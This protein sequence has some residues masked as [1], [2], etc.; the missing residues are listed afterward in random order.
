MKNIFRN[1]FMASLVVAG[2]AYL[3]SCSKDSEVENII[4]EVEDVT[5]PGTEEEDGYFIA[6][7][8]SG[9]YNPITRAAISGKSSRVQSLRYII[10]KKD[11]NG[12]YQYF[13]DPLKQN[14]KYLFG[15]S[16]KI[17]DG[18]SVM[19][20]YKPLSVKL[21]NGDYKFVFL[22]N[23][24]EKQFVNGEAQNAPIVTNYKG[25]YTDAR[26]NLPTV[27]GFYEKAIT[28][29]SSDKESNFFYWDTVEV[30]TS[31]PNAEVLLQRI[32]SKFEMSREILSTEDGS[33]ARVALTST[34]TKNIFDY[35]EGDGTITR[36][37]GGQIGEITRGVFEDLGID[38]LEKMLI[39]PIVN[40]LINGL[41][42][43]KIIEALTS[44]IDGVLK[45]NEKYDTNLLDLNAV[46]NP[47]G[48][49]A[50]HAIVA[51]DKYTKSVDLD[52][53][54][55]DYFVSSENEIPRFAYTVNPNGTV[56]PRTYLQIYGLNGEWKIKRIDA[57]DKNN[58]EVPDLISGQII[59]NFV[60][61]W[62]I[63][64]CVH[65]AAADLTYNFEANK[66]Y[67]SVFSDVT[68]NMYPKEFVKDENGDLSVT[69]N[70]GKVLSLKNILDG[71][72]TNIEQDENKKAYD[73]KNEIVELQNSKTIGA[74]VQDILSRLLGTVGNLLDFLT[75]KTV[76]SILNDVLYPALKEAGLGG[77]EGLVN[78]LV[79]NLNKDIT[80]KLPLNISLLNTENLE[81]SGGWTRVYDGELPEMQ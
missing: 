56:G 57:T 81:V 22:G 31:N 52:N 18:T 2:S 71:T 20:P 23:M 45:G 42:D 66:P 27:K 65:D 72:L 50:E 76:G 1:I 8:S 55:V 30:S 11:Q 44:Q 64:G 41:D 32:V 53:K 80:I 24:N 46:L 13:E 35:L 29:G 10:Y 61:G 33:N 5:T 37:I 25:T 34:L 70:L 7:L 16:G 69:V 68:L 58:G 67:H 77:K 63:D 3:A 12:K 26:I 19:W 51:F 36:L 6:T 59:D 75:G 4:D 15:E 74:F 47:W 79:D 54:P 40:A 9:L 28:E 48:Y 21:S 73:Y 14:D 39:D 49:D 62:L 60:D 17:E 38:A 43:T 78:K